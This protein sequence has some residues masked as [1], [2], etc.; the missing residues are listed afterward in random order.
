MRKVIVKV[1]IF[2]GYWQPSVGDLV[3][4]KNTMQEGTPIVWERKESVW[5]ELQHSSS[6]RA[7][8]EKLDCGF[9][10]VTSIRYYHKG[11]KV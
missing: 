6:H 4:H 9:Y 1:R 2:P 3:I 7:D 11:D 5:L 8:L 10:Q